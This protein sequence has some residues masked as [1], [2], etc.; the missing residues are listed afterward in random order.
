MRA[1]LPRSQRRRLRR[2]IQRAL[3]AARHALKAAPRSE[4]A[5]IVTNALVDAIAQPSELA[6]RPELAPQADLERSREHDEPEAHF[7]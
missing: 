2:A 4:H 5:D 6:P 7:R 3:L 1:G